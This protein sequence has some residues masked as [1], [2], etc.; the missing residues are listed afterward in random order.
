MEIQNALRTIHQMHAD[1]VLG[2][3]VIGGAVGATFYL[4]P[5]STL[6]VDIFA[7]LPTSSGS[8]L[9]ATASAI[10]GS[11]TSSS[12]SVKNEPSPL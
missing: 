4:E 12:S 3:Y 5:V 11:G 10:G 2:R 8:A 1:D 7:E 9:V 6:D